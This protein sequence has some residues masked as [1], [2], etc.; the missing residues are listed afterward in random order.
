[1]NYKQKIYLLV[2][3]TLPL[4]GME[5]YLP[6]PSPKTQEALDVF[7]GNDSFNIQSTEDIKSPIKHLSSDGS[8]KPLKKRK[9]EFTIQLSERL[10]QLHKDTKRDLAELC[11]AE[12]DTFF[13]RLQNLMVFKSHANKETQD[14]EIKEI[15]EK[16]LANNQAILLLLSTNYATL[17]N[18]R[19]ELMKIQS[20]EEIFSSSPL[21]NF[22]S[23]KQHN[24]TKEIFQFQ[25]S[26]MC[27]RNTINFFNDQLCSTLVE[28]AKIDL[29]Q[30]REEDDEEESENNNSSQRA[31]NH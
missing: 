5:P 31:N 16:T 3:A 8:D 17:H 6:K 23:E 14:Y 22:I 21:F 4:I 13:G 25:T 1:M 18:I 9:I 12:C 20:Q 2:L 10:E 26:D 28:I 11:N 7:Q 15:A 27:A 29:L 30:Q 24:N 19:E